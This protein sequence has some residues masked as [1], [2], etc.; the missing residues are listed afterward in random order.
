ML[1]YNTVEILRKFTRED[2]RKLG[3]FIKSPYFNTK[4]TL[5]LLFKEINKEYPELNEEKFEYKRIYKKIYGSE[6]KEQTIKN[7]YSELGGLLKKF[8]AHERIENNTLDFNISLIRGFRDKKC[9]EQ[10]SKYIKAF[11]KEAEQKPLLDEHYFSYLYNLDYT[12]YDNLLSMNKITLSDYHTLYNS[13]LDNVTYYFLGAFFFFQQEDIIISKAHIVKNN[14]EFTNKVFLNYFDSENFFNSIQSHPYT[15]AVKIRYLF[16]KYTKT[17]I[18]EEEFQEYKKLVYG[19]LNSMDFAIQLSAWNH[20]LTLLII[21]LI[22]KDKKYYQDAFELNDYF[23]KLNIYPFENCQA[24][25]LS[26]FRDVFG[27]ALILKKFDWAKNFI[28]NF[29]P[30]LEDESQENEINYAMG[31][32]D[33]QLKNYEKSLEHLGKVKFQQVLEKIN[34]RFYYLMNY[35]ELKSYQS[36][37]SMLNSIRQFYFESK[38]IPEMFAVLMD[39]SLKYFREIIRV[40]ENNKKLDYSVLKEAQNAGRYYQKQYILEKMEKLL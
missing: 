26:M 2:I 18:S 9:F 21:K 27:I 24:F 23:L 1:P 40:E 17:D 4:E 36:A 6:F 5:I 28:D 34:I 10:S 35:I 19:T 3:E 22:P 25:P 32:L 33:F 31:R 29:S 14:T 20:I 15:D 39:N 38:E 37:I 30:Y 7:L 12:Y 8:I 13:I 16:Y 11:K